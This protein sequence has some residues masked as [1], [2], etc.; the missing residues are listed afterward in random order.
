MHHQNKLVF[1]FHSRLPEGHNISS[2]GDQTCEVLEILPSLYIEMSS[3]GPEKAVTIRYP[4]TANLMIDS[5]DR[6]TTRNPSAW[7]FQI[8]KNQSIQNG[9]FTRV[10]TTEVV[11]EWCEPN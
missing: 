8:T 1:L 9:F 11:L 2:Q 6:N 7:D 3:Y 10:G 5:S 4:A